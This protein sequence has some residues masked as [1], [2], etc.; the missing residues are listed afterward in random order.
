MSAM[1]NFRTAALA[2][3][4]FVIP[5]AIALAHPAIDKR[6]ELLIPDKPET[7][8][9]TPAGRIKKGRDLFL[10]ET[11]NGNGRTCGTCHAPT[12]NFTIDPDFIA[13]LPITNPLFVA[14]TKPN[15]AGLENPNLMHHFGLILE[16][17]DGFQ[18]PG[19]MRG[20]P[21]TLALSTSI[22]PQAG[23]P[24]KN[25]TG[26]SG[27]GAPF[28]GSLLNFVQGAIVQHFTK[29]LLR[30]PGV[31]FRL[32][33]KQEAQDL[34]EFQLSLGRKTDIS[35]EGD[36]SPALVFNDANVE[37]G[38]SLFL[39]TPAKNGTRSCNACHDEAGANNN[40]GQNRQFDTGVALRGNAPACLDPAAPGDGGFGVAPV[41]TKTIGCGEAGVPKTFRGNGT[42][43]T[44]PLVE[45]A[46]TP[47]FFHNN[48]ASTIEDAIL[49]YTS[50][51]FASSPA[52][53][54]NPVVLNQTQI[55]QIGALL[56]TI[57]ARENILRGIDVDN[58]AIT[59]GQPEIPELIAEARSETNDAIRVLV[60]A[61]V[62]LYPGSTIIRLLQQ[63][64]EAEAAAI[65]P[66]QRV[67]SLRLAI[68]LKQQALSQIAQ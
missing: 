42:F 9:P 41:V 17:L 49:H 24:L 23:F 46:D 3:S 53:G 34:L 22:N 63:A 62:Q 61:Q 35:L 10:N 55:A 20:V 8:I 5:A 50:P 28:D 39:V 30:R 13:T 6:L 67:S 48:S 45:A 31:D 29:D 18:N 68:S 59:S 54:G 19:V 64:D 26:W 65:S 4:I 32:A 51:E 7:Q 2:A 1:I 27:D 36:E 47:P 57:N 37:T 15:L 60:D 16:N 52:G 21:H 58:E 56:R 33:T 66:A 25:A 44:P 43:N 11:F 40:A 38:K 14:E 12:N